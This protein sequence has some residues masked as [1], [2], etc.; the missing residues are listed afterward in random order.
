MQIQN[1]TDVF[2]RILSL[3]ALLIRTE[4]EGTIHMSKNPI[5]VFGTK[6][7]AEKF[8]LWLKNNDIYSYLSPKE[9][10]ALDLP[11][12]TWNQSIFINSSWRAESLA[13]L[14]WATGILDELPAYD[15]EVDRH[16]ILVLVKDFS[17]IDIIQNVAKFKDI[18]D[19][20]KQRDIAELWHWRANTTRIINSKSLPAGFDLKKMDEICTITSMKAYES[21]EIPTPIDND[22]PAFGKAY[23]NLNDDEFNTCLSISMERHF[24][25][26]WLCGESSS[27]DDTPTNT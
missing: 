13:V 8:N 16:K 21:G 20:T 4:F 10:F 6:V 3:K 24:G 22:F 15:T 27:W 11:I 18:A 19:I 7:A 12:G 2:K 1:Q 17:S 25:F 26:N 5:E 23:K 14:L 9:K